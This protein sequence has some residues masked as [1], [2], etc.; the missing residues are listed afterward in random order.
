[1]NTRSLRSKVIFPCLIATSIVLVLPAVARGQDRCLLGTVTSST[2]SWSTPCAIVP[3]GPESGVLC[4]G[5][6]DCQNPRTAQGF[7][8]FCVQPGRCINGYCA[9]AGVNG[10]CLPPDFVYCDATGGAHPECDKP[11]SPS[12]VP[13]NPS[14][15]GTRQCLDGTL[16]SPTCSWSTTCTPPPS[17]PAPALPSARWLGVL[18]AMLVAGGWWMLRLRSRVVD[19]QRPT[20]GA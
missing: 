9:F 8:P 14:V 13:P 7:R 17:P 20:G 18:A 6:T 4:S 11:L 10:T 15:C 1:M 19:L 3:Q 5:D 2:C 16:T 12:W